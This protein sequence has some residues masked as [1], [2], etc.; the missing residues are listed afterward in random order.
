MTPCLT[1]CPSPLHCERHVPPLRVC[2]HGALD[3]ADWIDSQSLV[4]TRIDV[5][6]R[7]VSFRLI[8]R[9]PCGFFFVLGLDKAGDDAGEHAA[10]DG[11]AAARGEGPAV[12]DSEADGEAPAP[13]GEGVG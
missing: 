13:R 9:E 4:L 10:A 2:L 6:D 7:V 1:P 3:A 11:A 8:A 5:S 12:A